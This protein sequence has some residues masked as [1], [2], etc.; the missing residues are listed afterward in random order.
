MNVLLWHL[1]GSYQTAM[2][3]GPHTYLIPTTPERGPEGRG[4]ADSWEWPPNAVEV[5]PRDCL[6]KEIDVAVF[7]RTE[8]LF[9][10]APRWLGGRR[11]GVDFP[12]VYLE[13]NAPQGRINDLRHPAAD[14]AGVTFV[15]VTHFNRLFWDVGASPVRVIEHGIPDPGYRYGGELERAVAVINEPCRRARVAGSDLL[16]FF[17]RSL[18]IDL[19][20]MKTPNDVPQSRLHEEM[21]RRRVYLHPYRWTSLGL[22]LIEAMQLGMPVVALDVT[23]HREAV[24]PDGGVVSNRPEVLSEALEW[25]GSDH[26][27]ARRMG[28][29]AR[30]WALRKY[31]LERFLDDWN[32]LFEEVTACA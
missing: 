28:C 25:L 7:Q 3:Q 27:A 4:R 6:E 17:E 23:E 21:P 13:H 32:R 22:S 5:T 11:P 26:D 18:P 15:M 24:P 10:W 8:E 20:G 12:A 19:F 9:S 31:G 29:R 2:V 30:E 14:L 16:P 1:H